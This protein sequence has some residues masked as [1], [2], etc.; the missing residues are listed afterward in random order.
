MLNQ[1]QI[2]L[3]YFYKQT[4]HSITLAIKKLNSHINFFSS[5]FIA[6]RKKK[7]NSNP[8]TAPLSILTFDELELEME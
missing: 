7:K 4:C 3:Q 8:H 5:L 2:L 1:L 6:L